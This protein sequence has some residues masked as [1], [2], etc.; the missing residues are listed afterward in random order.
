[1]WV[2]RDRR[3]ELNL[4]WMNYLSLTLFLDLIKIISRFKREWHFSNLSHCR[5]KMILHLSRTSL[6][7][8][9]VL[10]I[11]EKECVYE[12]KNDLTHRCFLELVSSILMPCLSMRKNMYMNVFP[13][14]SCR[15]W[16][17]ALF[18]YAQLSI[19]SL[20]NELTLCH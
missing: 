7:N 10:S 19:V 18:F 16:M 1:M 8:Y 4:A 5:I 17:Y 15:I 13:T 14:F 11:Y 20:N 9:Y 3:V 12:Y 2:F 6:F